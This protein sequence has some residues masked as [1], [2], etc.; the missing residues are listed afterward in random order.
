MP[1]HPET[2]LKT[3]LMKGTG[4]QAFGQVVQILIR[5]SEVPLLLAFWGTQLYG[6]WLMLSAIPAYL[7]IGDGGFS[8]AAC[9]DMT[10][11]SGA[12]DQQGALAVFQSTL[13][14]LLAVS[15]VAFLLAYN[16][17]ALAP[18]HQWLGFSIMTNHDTRMVLLLLVAHVL[19]GFQGGLLT[20]GFWVSGRYPT[21]MTLGAAT[22]LFEFFGLV[23]AVFLGGGP[24]QAAAGYFGGRVLGTGLMWLGQRRSSSWLRYGFAHAS[25]SELRRIAAPAFASLAFP[26]GNALNIQGIRLVVGLAL[27]PAAVAVFA[28]MRTMTNLALQP[29]AVINRLI[30]PELARAFGAENTFLFRRL[31]GKSCQLSLWSCLLAALAVC[32]CSYW[33]FPVWTDGKVAFHLPVF[34]LLVAGA[35]V[36]ASWYTALMVLYA[37]NRHVLI[38]LFYTLIYGAVAICIGYLGAAS[39]GLGGACFGL[40]LVEAVMAVIVIRSSLQMTQMKISSW[41][42]TTFRPPIEII[43][44]TS[45]ILRRLAITRFSSAIPK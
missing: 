25:L 3:R 19:V 41:V 22:N 32:G 37:T 7:A 9:R 12:G 14:L 30:E 5:L 33:L 11:K 10:M 28:P 42:R 29:R 44:Q 17:S 18:L 6:E 39:M 21:G 43:G 8:G 38:A 16:F 4:A 1:T 45:F 31:F 35:L 20:G 26:L 15:V 23:I 27:G 40:L 36:N 24:V 13:L 2:T 34:L